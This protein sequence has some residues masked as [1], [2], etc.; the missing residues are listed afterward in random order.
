MLKTWL[1]KR[2]SKKGL[3]PLLS[4]KK[5]CVKSLPW[6]KTA[7]WLVKTTAP[8]LNTLWVLPDSIA[9]HGWLEQ[10]PLIT[11]YHTALLGGDFPPAQERLWKK[12]LHQG[13]IHTVILTS[14]MAEKWL[15][16]N[17][18]ESWLTPFN[19][20]TWIDCLP[21]EKVLLPLTQ[22][23]NV[24]HI[25]LLNPPIALPEEA[26]NAFDDVS[27]TVFPA[28]TGT[29]RRFAFDLLANDALLRKIKAHPQD[30]PFIIICPSEETLLASQKLLME[31]HITVLSL[32]GSMPW[33]LFKQH[34]AQWFSKQYPPIL[35][36][37]ENALPAFLQQLPTYDAST[38]LAPW[39]WVWLAPPQNPHGIAL[40]CEALPFMLHVNCHFVK[41]TTPFKSL[42]LTWQWHILQKTTAFSPR[43]ALPQSPPLDQWGTVA[44]L[45]RLLYF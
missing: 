26:E 12:R 44:T 11:Q 27:A 33:Q 6:H 17:A 20:L 19:Q 37:E 25:T 30:A 31:K 2:S 18:S 39:H 23:D 28:A 22:A 32:S 1:E 45:N 16:N 9:A 42:A 41:E 40:C 38:F 21:T 36:L 3:L 24:T 15:K 5:V 8:P 43:I 13:G 34:L 4:H 35:L 10:L 29:L 14:E 7:Q